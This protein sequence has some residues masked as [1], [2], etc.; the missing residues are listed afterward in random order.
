MRTE[1]SASVHA[2]F[3]AAPRRQQLDVVPEA[4]RVGNV[5]LYPNLAAVTV[6]DVSVAL[7]PK[8]FALVR[9]LF[10]RHGVVVSHDHCFAALGGAPG[11]KTARL[12]R[13]Y[14]FALR[15]KLRAA[16]AMVVLAA[17]RGRGYVLREVTY[18]R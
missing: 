5:T 11:L 17:V 2:N 8:E 12:L 16:G 18:R 10:E 13:V 7:S 15:R 14:I 4:R 3:E 1:T 9:T 6:S